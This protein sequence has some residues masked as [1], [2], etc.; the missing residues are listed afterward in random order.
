M[1]KLQL[2]LD[3]LAVESFEVGGGGRGGTVRTHQDS[4]VLQD[5][6]GTATIPAEVCVG[7]GGGGGT[8]ET[9]CGTCTCEKYTC[10]E[11]CRCSQATWC[12]CETTPPADT[13]YQSCHWP[14]TCPPPG[15]C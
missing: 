6:G 4:F 12:N 13:C 7:G 5:C 11:T 3:D 8:N 1:Q 10:Q 2:K 15:V 14:I 9:A